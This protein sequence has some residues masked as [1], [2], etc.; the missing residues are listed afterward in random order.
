[1]WVDRMLQGTKDGWSDE[2]GSPDI[3]YSPW[4]FR[5]NRGD[6]YHKVQHE[7]VH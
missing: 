7:M 3:H 2:D 6:K 4:S 1:M 5:L